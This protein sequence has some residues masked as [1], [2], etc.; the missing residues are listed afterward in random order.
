MQGG[1]C[2]LVVLCSIL[3]AEASE[4]LREFAEAKRKH[5]IDDYP[6][7]RNGP[8]V[9]H[10]VISVAVDGPRKADDETGEPIPG[11]DFEQ[12]RVPV[13]VWWGGELGDLGW[14]GESPLSLE[15][16]MQTKL[17]TGKKYRHRIS[18]G[19]V[20]TLLGQRWLGSPEFLPSNTFQI[21]RGT[22]PL[23]ENFAERPEEAILFTHGFLGS[24]YEM[25]HV[26]ERLAADGFV[27]MAPEFPESLTGSFPARHFHT[28]NYHNEAAEEIEA[29]GQRFLIAKAARSLLPQ[30]TNWGIFGHAIGALHAQAQPG[31]YELGRVAIAPSIGPQSI[32]HYYRGVDPFFLV[33]TEGDGC[34]RTLEPPDKAGS[35]LELAGLIE[36]DFTP[37]HHYTVAHSAYATDQL[38]EP[39]GPRRAALVFEE[40]TE[41]PEVEYEAQ[42]AAEV[43]SPFVRDL[44]TPSPLPNHLS[45]LYG[46]STD[47]LL[48]FLGPV[49][50]LSRVLGFRTFLPDLSV[51]RKNRDFATT[52][53]WY[54]APVRR[55]FRA[56]KV[57]NAGSSA[58]QGGPPANRGGGG[59]PQN[60][61]GGGGGDPPPD[62]VGRRMAEERSYCPR[63]DW[64]DWA[65]GAG[66]ADVLDHRERLL[67]DAWVAGIR[68]AEAAQ[69]RL[70]QARPG[71]RQPWESFAVAAAGGMLIGMA[72]ATA[73]MVSGWTRRQCGRLGLVRHS[74]YA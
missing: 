41:V 68:E 32:N 2:V 34:Y 6:R 25:T 16:Q 17:V 69:Q 53:Q 22:T 9:N 59:P 7:W 38:G 66:E 15:M 61:G 13:S 23:H 42:T 65:A 12:L 43:E 5:S 3:A 44:N 73:I 39:V 49:L 4:L 60:G 47:A 40:G 51:Y 26:C 62:L 27:V 64:F 11:A 10:A 31:Q 8:E 74:S 45:F 28:L 63:P 72:S 1:G 55:F 50:P 70:A 48:S 56:Y 58:A 35:P 18:L 19:R 57:P 33:T 14:F 20:A 37:I 30:T 46:P 71:Q 52:A 67:V 29:L 54:V 36:R 21:P 24:P